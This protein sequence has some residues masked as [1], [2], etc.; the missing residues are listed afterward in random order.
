VRDKS[1]GSTD[2]Y[3]AQGQA[4][5]GKGLFVVLGIVV[6]GAAVAA[7]GYALGRTSGVDLDAARS[8]AERTGQVQGSELGG[9][10]GY[11]AGFEE[12]RR[13]AYEREIEEGEVD[14]TEGEARASDSAESGDLQ[15]GAADRIAQDGLTADPE[16]TFIE[17]SAVDPVW[18]IVSGFA[19]EGESWVVWYR[20]GE[21]IE[22]G[23]SDEDR[24]D[25]APCDLAPFSEDR[26]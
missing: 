7:A 2:G 11:Q 24:P 4:A 17:E 18:A 8:A 21:V 9:E 22:G 10:R 12:G 16:Q 23:F 14:A 26:C 20:D 6:V 3:E 15:Q 25:E 13:D 5:K 1:E 19:I